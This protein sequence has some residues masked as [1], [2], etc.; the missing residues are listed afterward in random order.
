MGPSVEQAQHGASELGTFGSLASS[1]LDASEGTVAMEFSVSVLHGM[2]AMESK[3]RA[4]KRRRQLWLW[5]RQRRKDGEA[6][7]ECLDVSRRPGPRGGAAVDQGLARA[8]E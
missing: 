4:E 2:A 8:P 5:G 3:R 6:L 7:R 1:S